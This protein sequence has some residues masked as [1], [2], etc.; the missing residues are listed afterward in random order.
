MIEARK[1]EYVVIW[2]PA[3]ILVHRE[4]EQELPREEAGKYSLAKETTFKGF[5]VLG[6]WSIETPGREWSEV[7][8]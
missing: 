8:T 1:E 6:N 3:L 7:R 4:D 5:E 2:R